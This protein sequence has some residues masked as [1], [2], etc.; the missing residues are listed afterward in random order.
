MYPGPSIKASIA[1]CKALSRVSVPSTAWRLNRSVVN[2]FTDVVSTGQ[3][4]TNN[5]RV[6]QSDWVKLGSAQTIRPR[7]AAEPGG[8][9]F[10][11]FFKWEVH[12]SLVELKTCSKNPT[13]HTN[14]KNDACSIIIASSWA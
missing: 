6:G 9:A 14:Y 7:H 10:V 12:T 13:I 11:P 8:E 3:L 1:C 4:L 5:A 2:V